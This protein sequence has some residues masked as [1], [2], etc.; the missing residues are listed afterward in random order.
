MAL[1]AAVSRRR[2]GEVVGGP[3][4]VNAG[5]RQCHGSEVK[6]D[7]SGRPTPETWPNTG[8]GRAVYPGF[9]QL[10]GFMTMNLDRH[11]QAQKDMFSHLVHGDG[12]S[13]D[14]HREFYD[15]YLAVMDVTAKAIVPKLRRM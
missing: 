14:K 4:A 15:E 1:H 2:L 7:S 8:M 11:M 12:D 6:V 10:T 9:L 5:C 3:P 13:A